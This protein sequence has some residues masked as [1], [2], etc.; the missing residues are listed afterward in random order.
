MF[1][2][3]PPTWRYSLSLK[4]VHNLYPPQNTRT[5]DYYHKHLDIKALVTNNNNHNIFSLPA[6]SCGRAVSL[7]YMLL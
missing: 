5:L 6:P 2:E 4:A 3:L 7:S 1:L